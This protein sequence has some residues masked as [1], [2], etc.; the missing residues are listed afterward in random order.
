MSQIRKKMFSSQIIDDFVRISFFPAPKIT[1]FFIFLIFEEKYQTNSLNATPF[2]RITLYGSIEHIHKSILQDPVSQEL[3][4]FPQNT[5]KTTP[6][7]PKAHG[8]LLHHILSQ[9]TANINKWWIKNVKYLSILT[10]L[11]VSRLIRQV[12]K[13]T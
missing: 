4:K 1:I 8:T 2:G 11:T 10:S 5:L 7:V 13:L 12:C 6:S 9:V 3:F